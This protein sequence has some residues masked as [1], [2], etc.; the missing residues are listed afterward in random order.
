M[1][2]IEHHAAFSS[3]LPKVSMKRPAL[4]LALAL[5]LPASLH[6]DDASKQAKVRELFALLHVERISDQIK[7][8]VMNQTA[9]IPQQL[10][11]PSMS[12]ENKAKF[13]AFQQ[14]VLQT[15]DAQ[16]GWKVLEPEYVQ[17]Y[18]Q[19]YTEDELNGIVAFYKTSAGA[20]MIAK[21]PQL[22]AK[23][24][25]LVQSKMAAVQPQLKQMVEDFVRESKPAS[26]PTS[27]AATPAT[28]P[29]TTPK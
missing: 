4:L 15:V 18:A 28:P 22:S 29:T 5:C 17:L 16:V 10:F 13:E 26:T 21:S 14:K 2:F 25:G 6:A 24:I 8:N 3:P 7:S 9:A 11:G 12:P 20:A 27:P 19:T 1:Y 23:S